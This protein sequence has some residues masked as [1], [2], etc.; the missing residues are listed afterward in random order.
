M[1]EM[2]TTQETEIRRITVQSQSREN[3]LQDAI[4]KKTYHKR[5]ASG[6]LQEVSTPA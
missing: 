6:E 4:S 1:P 2:L 3:S 5:R